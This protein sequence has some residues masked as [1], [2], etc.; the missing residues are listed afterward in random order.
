MPTT[1]KCPHCGHLLRYASSPTAEGGTF[2]YLWC[3]NKD[4]IKYRNRPPSKLK[5]KVEPRPKGQSPS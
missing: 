5:L 1:E 2:E 4:C 3:D